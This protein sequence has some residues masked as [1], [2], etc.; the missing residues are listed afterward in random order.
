MSGTSRFI[1]YAALSRFALRQ[2]A[3][4]LTAADWI[5]ALQDPAERAGGLWDLVEDYCLEQFALPPVGDRLGR[6]G[7][8]VQL[9]PAVRIV[10][11]WQ[12]LLPTRVAAVSPPF[13]VPQLTSA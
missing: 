3:I 6:S 7:L 9:Q 12:R 4:H 10:P 11:D 13:R 5:D 1:S 2:E 8:T